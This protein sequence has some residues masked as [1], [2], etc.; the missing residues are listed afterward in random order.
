MLIYEMILGKAPFKGADEEEIFEAILEDDVLF[1]VT[2]AK[3][4]VSL[5]QKVPIDTLYKK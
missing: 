5:L 4:A 3:E 1:P 2:M